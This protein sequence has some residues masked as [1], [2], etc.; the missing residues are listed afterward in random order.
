MDELV[1][2][3]FEDK[4]SE[5]IL[6]MLINLNRFQINRKNNIKKYNKLRKLHVEILSSMQNY[7]LI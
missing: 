3:L 1:K 2:K 7:I 5:K 4:P 6:D